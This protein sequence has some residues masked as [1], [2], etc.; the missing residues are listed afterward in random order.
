MNSLN[1]FMSRS[2]EFARALASAEYGRQPE[3]STFTRKTFIV[4]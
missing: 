2:Q 4:V 3:G 1:Q